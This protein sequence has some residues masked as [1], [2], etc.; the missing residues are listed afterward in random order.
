MKTG[1][2]DHGERPRLGVFYGRESVLVKIYC[3]IAITEAAHEGVLEPLQPSCWAGKRD[4]RRTWHKRLA[5]ARPGLL[6]GGQARRSPYV[7]QASRLCAIGP[8]PKFLAKL[9]KNDCDG[10]AGCL[11]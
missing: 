2:R 8:T 11:G 9:E 3:F 10:E 4:A 6:L 5:C 7:A 1:S